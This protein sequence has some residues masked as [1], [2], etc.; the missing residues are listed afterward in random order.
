MAQPTPATFTMSITPFR[1]DGSIDEP[2]LRTHL[3]FQAEAGVG[4]CLCSQGSGEGDLLS[5]DERLRVYEIGVDELK[6]R[7]PVYA[8]G[9]GLAHSTDSIVAL[10]KRACEIGVDALYILGPRPGAL[11]PRAIEIETYYREIIEA[12]QCSVAISNNSALAGYSFSADLIESLVADY[13]HIIE[14]LIADNV[15][16]LINQ[17]HRLAAK[18]GDAITIRVGMSSQSILAHAAGARGILNFEANIAPR[19]TESLWQ[20]LLSGDSERALSRF[21]LFVELNLL[22]SRF[23][24][25]RVIKE[26]LRLLGR[27]GGHLRR[28]HLPLDSGESAD[29]A[30]G[31]ARL[32]LQNIEQF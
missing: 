32:Q 8:A 13:P 31:L 20:A 17:V 22:C 9:I 3:R 7:V 15:G 6:G 26:A 12:T 29:L 16:P 1:S 28:P 5:F 4:V 18:F 19:L 21:A 24:N 25:P 23:G 27:D 2:A 10:A 11:T 30:A 14:V